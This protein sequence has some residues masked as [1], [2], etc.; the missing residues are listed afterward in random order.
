VC[1]LIGDAEQ[2]HQIVCILIGDAEQCHQIVCILIGDAEQCHRVTDP[3][4]TQHG[5]RGAETSTRRPEV[6]QGA[7]EI[8]TE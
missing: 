5:D 4:T 6:Q 7:G 2:R 8:K 3:A 1:I